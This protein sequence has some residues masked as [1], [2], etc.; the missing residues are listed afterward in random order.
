MDVRRKLVRKTVAIL[1]VLIVAAGH[2]DLAASGHGPVFGGATPTLGKGD[3]SSTAS[4][5]RRNRTGDSDQMLRSMRSVTDSPK[6]CRSPASLPIELTST[7]RMPM[8]RM[9][10]MMSANREAEALVGWRFQRKEV[11]EGARL[12]STAYLGG[13]VPLESTG[14][15]SAPHHRRMCPRQQATR[16]AHITSGSAGAISAPGG[17]R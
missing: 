1:A 15:A 8:G 5:G 11:G 9:T 12:E 16:H 14:R 2:R 17:R 6:I 4:M 13:T 7:G 10:A 3:W